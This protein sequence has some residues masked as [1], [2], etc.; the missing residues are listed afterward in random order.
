MLRE[1]KSERGSPANLQQVCAEL[2]RRLGA[3]EAFSAEDLFASHPELS[4]DADAALEVIYTEFVARERLG[5]LPAP[6]NFCT[7]FPALREG[8]EQLFQIHSEAG[9]ANEIVPATIGTPFPDAERLRILAEPRLD[10][11]ARRVGNYEI[12]GEVGRGGM[13]VVYKARQVGLNRLVALKMILTGADAGPQERAR[14]RTEAEAAARLQHPNIVQIYEVGEHDGRPFLSL[15]FVDGGS[16]DELLTGTPWPAAESAR[17]V[18]TL[19]RAM[20]HAHQQGIVHR[21]LKPANILLSGRHESL[22]REESGSDTSEPVT[23]SARVAALPSRLN[24][25]VPKITDFG[26]ARRLLPDGRTRPA[27]TASGAIVGTPAYMAPE[28]AV[29]DAKQIGRATDVYALGAILY[30]LLTGRPPFQGVSVLETLEQVRT[31]EPVPPSRLLPKLPRDI[32]TICLKCLHKEPARRYESAADLAD[33]LARFQRGKPV[34]ARPTPAW[35]KTMKWVKRRPAVAGLLFLLIIVIVVSLTTVT[36]LWRKTAAALNTAEEERDKTATALAAN[37]VTEANRD[38]LANDMDAARRHLEECPPAYRDR[39]W[40]YLHR[41]SHACL[42]V[43]GSVQPTEGKITSVAWSRN[44]RH[45]AANPS[46]D[47]VKVWVAATGD[48]CFKLA[49]HSHWVAKL[50]FNPDGRLVSVSWPRSNP[51][52]SRN[53]EVKTWEMEQGREVG[54][55]TMPLSVSNGALSADGQRLAVAGRSKLTLVDISDRTAVATI[56]DQPTSIQSVT[57]SGDGRVLAWRSDSE[58]IQIWDTVAKAA[59]DQLLPG[60]DLRCLALSPDGS[61]LAVGGFERVREIGV[62]RIFEY[63]TGRELA[64]LR[65]H[66]NPITCAEFSPDGRRL[67]TASGDKTVIVWDVETGRELFTFRGHFGSVWAL[68]FSPD[69]TRLASGGGDATVRIWD[70]RPLD[71]NAD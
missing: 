5:Q 38:W 67:A 46:G 14:F 10:G 4:N 35:E 71:D 37:L 51:S 18:Q 65:G 42:I 3:G 50:A 9:G 1:V 63:R 7:R 31:Q 40:R 12:L 8:L 33:D 19:A 49:G 45:V 60:Q 62:T 55:F 47:P 2:E 15:Q 29:G 44:G 68:A 23:R 59:V 39:Q 53:L 34:H 6:D 32:E 36:V 66:T 17:L 52:A 43:L 54:A 26:L 56:G 61:R 16:L 70:V 21:D 25:G 48:E 57:L 64:V 28:Q 30:E 58:T 24:S 20:H 41:V 69:G 27:L 11:A 22:S 13:G